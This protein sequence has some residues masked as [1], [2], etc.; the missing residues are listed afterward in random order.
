MM[1]LDAGVEYDEAEWIRCTTITDCSDP[2]PNYWKNEAVVTLISDRFSARDDV[3]TS[4][5]DYLEK[6]RWDGN[7]VSHLM[8]WM[9][10]NQATGDAAAR[11]F[12]ENYEEIWSEWVPVEIAGKIKSAL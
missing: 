5:I 8:A 4:V 7:T 2:K 6:R 3:S 1:R 10:D 9:T 12:I 11:H